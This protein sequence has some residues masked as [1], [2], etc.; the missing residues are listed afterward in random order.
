MNR[1]CQG[2]TR[3]KKDSGWAW[4]ILLSSFIIFLL[5]GGTL[6]SLSVLLPT[7]REQFATRTSLIGVIIAAMNAVKDLSGESMLFV[8]VL[9]FVLLCFFLFDCLF[10]CFVF[11]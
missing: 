5:W 8:F 1:K 10:C 11:V 9:F 2:G 4:M 3:C 6:K 7:L